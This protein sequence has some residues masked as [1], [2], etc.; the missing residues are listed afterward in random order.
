MFKTQVNFEFGDPLL[1]E[2]FI[3]WWNTKGKVSYSCS[4]KEPIENIRDADIYKVY[5]SA[6]CIVKKR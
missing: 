6:R 2:K 3:D 1:R 4:I 5:D